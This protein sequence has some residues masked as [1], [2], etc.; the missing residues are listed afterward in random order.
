M[1]LNLDVT[2]PLILVPSANAPPGTNPP[3][4][5]LDLGHLVINHDTGP[6]EEI[7]DYTYFYIH[8]KKIGAYVQDTDLSPLPLGAIIKPFD[9]NLEIGTKAVVGRPELPAT[10]VKGKLD[11]FNVSVTTEKVKDI[12]RVATSIQPPSRTKGEDLTH[13]T[14]RTTKMQKR[15]IKLTESVG[16]LTA[17]AAADW[18][19]LSYTG[20]QPSKTDL[21]PVTRESTL[22]LTFQLGKVTAMVRDK[23]DPKLVKGQALVKA[24]IETLNMRVNVSNWD[25]HATLMLDRS[26]SLLLPS[27]PLSAPLCPCLPLLP[28]PSGHSCPSPARYFI[29]PFP[30]PPSFS[31]F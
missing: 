16:S 4:V 15:G 30:F 27:P 17:Q 9:I 6:P 3:I 18:S 22:E 24:K 11:K 5:I 21:A 13:H 12:L 10:T 28:L 29:F 26:A 7:I 23:P 20:A 25:T 2:A 8:L 14:K 1:K 31:S 19:R